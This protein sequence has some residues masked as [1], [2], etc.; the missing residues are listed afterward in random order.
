VEAPEEIK[1]GIIGAIAEGDEEENSEDVEAT[2]VGCQENEEKL[3]ETPE[4]S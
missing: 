3:L 1:I 2:P 4:S